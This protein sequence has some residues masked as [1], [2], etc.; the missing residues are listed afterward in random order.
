MNIVYLAT[1]IAAVICISI[2]SHL[3]VTGALGPMG[4]LAATGLRVRGIAGAVMTAAAVTWA[5]GVSPFW[6]ELAPA[7]AH[8]ARP[9]KPGIA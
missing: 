6:A 2:A 9:P 7:P 4:L 3:F 8:F 5:G 1:L